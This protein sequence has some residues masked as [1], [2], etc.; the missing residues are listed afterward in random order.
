[1]NDI[2]SVSH[3][4]RLRLEKE[5]PRWQPKPAKCIHCADRQRPIGV[6]WGAC[7]RDLYHGKVREATGLVVG[8]RRL[9]SSP[10]SLVL[11]GTSG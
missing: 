11:R 5:E 6:C 1:M 7:R 8:V 3:R 9:S 10:N 2:M 4:S